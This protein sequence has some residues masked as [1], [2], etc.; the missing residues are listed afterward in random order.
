MTNEAK[1]I[2]LKIIKDNISAPDYDIASNPKVKKCFKDLK[3]PLLVIRI[4]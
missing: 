3:S 4:K 1:N 2:I